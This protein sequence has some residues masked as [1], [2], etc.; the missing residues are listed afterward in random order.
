MT[1]S[2]RSSFSTTVRSL[3]HMRRKLTRWAPSF[4]SSSRLRRAS[5]S[6]TFTARTFTSMSSGMTR[7]SSTQ[8]IERWFTTSPDKGESMKT[9]EEIEKKLRVAEKELR[10][11]RARFKKWDNHD[12]MDAIETLFEEVTTLRWVLDLPEPKR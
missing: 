12:D 11:T 5:A 2:I 1:R 10:A 4:R 8:D 3:R 7:S 9:S 6:A